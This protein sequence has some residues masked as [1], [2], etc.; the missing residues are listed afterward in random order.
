MSQLMLK[1][2]RRS[3]AATLGGVPGVGSSG[4]NYTD[5]IKST[6]KKIQSATSTAR[7]ID[8]PLTYKHEMIKYKMLMTEAGDVNQVLNQTDK[9]HRLKKSSN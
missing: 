9:K 1:A 8:I 3:M 4:D 6:M 7:P 2:R 5:F